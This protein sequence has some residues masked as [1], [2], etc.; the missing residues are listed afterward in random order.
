MQNSLQSIGFQVFPGVANYLLTYLPSESGYSSNKFVE[1]CQSKSLFV[2]DAQNMGISLPSNAVRFAIR[3][4]TENRK[5]LE[6]VTSIIR[7]K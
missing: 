3:T 5:M 7:S 2:R 4:K 6:I 1:E